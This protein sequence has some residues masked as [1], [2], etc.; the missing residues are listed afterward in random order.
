MY[1][2]K[3]IFYINVY[4]IKVNRLVYNLITFNE[5]DYLIQTDDQNNL[6]NNELSSCL[7]LLV[8]NRESLYWNNR[9]QSQVLQ[10]M[11]LL[12]HKQMYRVTFAWF[13][14]A[15]RKTG[16]TCHVSSRGGKL[17]FFF[18]HSNLVHISPYIDLYKILLHLS[19]HFLLNLGI[20][21]ELSFPL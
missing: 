21:T 4:S 9:T 18:I 13:S 15:W 1:N 8:T 20:C 11:D 3:C 19:S 7:I 2:I 10:C 5:Q 6:R 17:P 16:P 14:E 12:S